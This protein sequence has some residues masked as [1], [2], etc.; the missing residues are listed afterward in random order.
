VQKEFAARLGTGVK[1]IAVLLQVTVRTD[2]ATQMQ[3]RRLAEKRPKSRSNRMRSRIGGKSRPCAGDA[4]VPAKQ[5]LAGV[6]PPAPSIIFALH[7]E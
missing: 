1:P 2:N 3:M 6:S 5:E 4:G 7:R